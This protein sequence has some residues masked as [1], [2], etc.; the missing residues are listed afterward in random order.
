MFGI[1]KLFSNSDKHQLPSPE[2]TPYQLIGGEAGTR[3]L[4]N[5]FYDVMERDPHA[6]A[7]LDIHPQPMDNIRERFFEFLS[8]WLGGP[9][10]FVE[11]YGH[12]RLRARHLPFKVTKHQRD[13]W[14]LCMN[15]AIDKVVDNPAL[16][17]HLRQSF[18]KLATH[19]I[20]C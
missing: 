7:L 13:L 16:Q 8:G 10:L 15:Q 5:Q 6:K 9:D 2:Q 20:N 3:A 11:K 12:P 1:K 17:D 14:M 18:G 19:M 4:A